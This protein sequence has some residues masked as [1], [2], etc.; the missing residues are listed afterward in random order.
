M[1]RIIPILFAGFW[2]LA[3]FNAAL[4]TSPLRASSP[5]DDGFEYIVD[6]KD[7]TLYFAKI[8]TKVSDTVVINMRV[9][10]DPDSE[11]KDYVLVNAFKCRERL[12]KESG[13]QWRPVAKNT[14]GDYTLEFGC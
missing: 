14:V 13:G 4:A 6:A 5:Q 1:A 2:G 3:P 7:G 12:V 11:E 8:E 10:N 9:V